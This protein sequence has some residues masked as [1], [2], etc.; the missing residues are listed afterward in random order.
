MSVGIFKL[1]SSIFTTE[2]KEALFPQLEYKIPGMD[3]D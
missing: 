3:S 1:T 2:R